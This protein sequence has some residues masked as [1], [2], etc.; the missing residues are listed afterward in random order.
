[1]LLGGGTPVKLNTALPSGG[2]V[3]RDGIQFSSDGSRVLY[4]ADQ[5]TNGVVELYSRVVKQMWNVASGQ[6][7]GA[8][9]WDQGEVPDEVMSIHVNPVSFATVT[10]PSSDT[11]IFSL[12]I[13]PMDTGVA[14]LA[15]QPSVTLSVLDQTTISSR[16]A[17][18]GSGHFASREGL[19][20]DGNIELDGMT[21]AAPRIENNGVIS[22]SGVIDAQL[23]NRADGEVRVA[24][25]QRMHLSDTG[26]QSNAGRI[27]VIGNA[28]Q[29]AEIEFN[30]ELTNAV[31]MGN[32]TAR[33][34]IMRFNGGLTNQGNVGIFFGTSDVYGDIDNQSK[35]SI[36]V[37]G[38]GSATFWDDL[39]NDGTVKVSKGSAAVYFGAVS[40]NERFFGSGTNFF[41]GDL[42]PGSSPGTMSF[43]G[44]IVLGVTSTTKI[45]LGGTT[46]GE[47]HDHL[48]VRGT[49]NLDGA[50]ACS[51]VRWA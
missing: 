22:G 17:L 30:G 19:V 20:N 6:W 44:D 1:M 7:D 21:I 42:S 45:E 50:P 3:Y 49:A 23:Q 39:V 12:D 9:N 40:G 38:S 11:N 36:T 24:A 4:L 37:T 26:S 10:G 25:G 48:V 15:L 18:A 32:I 14:T 41:E 5:E 43:D 27:D 33:H 46:A 31:S 2:F 51:S 8:A 16:G 13:G 28:T 34:A 29:A 35:A 47:Q